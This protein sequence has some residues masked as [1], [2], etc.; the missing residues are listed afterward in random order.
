M[1]FFQYEQ[2]YQPAYPADMPN[3]DVVAP[4]SVPSAPD[5]GSQ[6]DPSIQPEAG[7]DQPRGRRRPRAQVNITCLALISIKLIYVLYSSLL[8]RLH[9]VW[10]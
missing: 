4:M 5:G 6:A 8:L 7:E 2:A 1:I 10:L 3:H 9:Q